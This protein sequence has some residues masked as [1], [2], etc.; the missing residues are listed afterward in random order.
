MISA[1]KDGIV[2]SINDIED[3]GNASV[4]LTVPVRVDQEELLTRIVR[5]VSSNR[6]K[7]HRKERITKAT[8]IRAYIDAMS[9]VPVDLANISDEKILLRRI[10]EALGRG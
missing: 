1:R 10:L 8:L 9:T 2:Q 5:T 6:D 3:R 4:R 7:K